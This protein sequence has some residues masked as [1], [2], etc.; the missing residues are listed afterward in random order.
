MENKTNFG[1]TILWIG[2][3]VGI[4]L[5]G[6][7]LLVVHE[8]DEKTTCDEPL[9]IDQR[10]NFDIPDTSTFRKCT[11]TNAHWEWGPK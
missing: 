1:G 5:S 6:C 7:N 4:I 9:P 2:L 11:H 8:E 10:N 3:H